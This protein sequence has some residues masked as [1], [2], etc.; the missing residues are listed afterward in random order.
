[1]I[2]DTNQQDTKKYFLFLQYSKEFRTQQVNQ[3]LKESFMCAFLIG[4]A[5][6]R[7]SINFFQLKT[8]S[9]DWLKFPYTEL[10]VRAKASTA[11]QILNM[12]RNPKFQIILYM[13]HIPDESH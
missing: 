3:L 5:T 12:R 2:G 6:N 9:M 4:C 13:L 10:C 1:M 7:Q 11:R 8:L